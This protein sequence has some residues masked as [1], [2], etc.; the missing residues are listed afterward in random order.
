MVPRT[1]RTSTT[2]AKP[3]HRPEE[4]AVLSRDL[5]VWHTKYDDMAC[6]LA[7]SVGSNRVIRFQKVDEGRHHRW[8]AQRDASQINAPLYLEL[9]MYCYFECRVDLAFMYIRSEGLANKAFMIIK[10]AHVQKGETK[11]FYLINCA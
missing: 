3:K 6:W 7:T 9:A 5:W 8:Q 10:S 2:E 1:L 4:H 11:A